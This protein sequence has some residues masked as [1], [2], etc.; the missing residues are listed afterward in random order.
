M[1]SKPLC[2]RLTDLQ[3]SAVPQDA[4]EMCLL[5]LRF[6][7]FVSL[8][9]TMLWDEEPV[10]ECADTARSRCTAL[11][12]LQQVLDAQIQSPTRIKYSE[13]RN[14]PIDVKLILK[15]KHLQLHE[16]KC[17]QEVARKR[18]WP[19]RREQLCDFAETCVRRIGIMLHHCTQ[20]KIRQKPP[21]WVHEVHAAQ[22]HLEDDR[23]WDKN[24]GSECDDFNGEEEADNTLSGGHRQ[25]DT[26]IG[27]FTVWNVEHGACWRAAG[28][29][30]SKEWTDT[31]TTGSDGG[32][33][34]DSSA[35]TLSG[36][37]VEIRHRVDLKPLI[38][39]Y[40]TV[41]GKCPISAIL[42]HP[43]SWMLKCRRS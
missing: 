43:I 26:A 9:F 27:F 34:Q 24:D 35:T 31:E 6:Q 41:D 3:V 5:N 16:E 17:L 18:G 4:L 11:N 38:S 33:A 2:R 30:A 10:D 7:V 23:A 32:E 19:S 21:V 13:L 12:G 8:G 40:E 42:F 14:P 25:P 22:E 29:N 37:K 20:A 1:I 28:P 39:L 15:S 36:H